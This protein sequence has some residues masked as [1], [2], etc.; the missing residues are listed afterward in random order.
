MDRLADG[1]R[2]LYLD[3]RGSGRT[4]LGDAQGLSLERSFA[5]LLSLLDGL[6]LAR[7]VLLGHS[8]GGNIVML[9]AAAHPDRVSSLV[10]AMPGPPFDN[11]G[12]AWEELEA[13]MTARRTPAD[14][15]EMGLIQRSDAFNRREPEAVEAFI[16][17]LYMPFF[18]DRATGATFRYGLSR[19]GAATAVEQEAMLFGDLDTAAAFAGL[20][21]I[22]SPTLVLSAELDP[23]PESFAVRVAAAIPGAVHHRLNGAGHF[24]FVE[25]P[26]AFF[27]VVTRFLASS[28]HV[29]SGTF[30]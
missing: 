3:Q 1:H 17:N 14:D 28:F 30:P 8:I 10:I 9:F 12:M 19:H 13:A 11:D 24:A 15:E 25:M 21:R 7:T 5:D 6:D 2:L 26:D 23:I 20:S 18:T 16:R 22:S 29:S 4:S 27:G